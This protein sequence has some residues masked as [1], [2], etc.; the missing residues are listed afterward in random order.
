MLDKLRKRLARVLSSESLPID[1]AA[2]SIVDGRF[3]ISRLLGEGGTSSV[4]AVRQLS[5]D[6]EIALK[7]LRPDFETTGNAWDHFIQETRAVSRLTSPHTI[8]VYDAGQTPEG[9]FYIAME[10]LK[11][12]SLYQLTL[13]EP[14]PMPLGSAAPLMGQVLD[15]VEES[16]GAGVLHRDLKPDNIFLLAGA[17]NG[18]FAKVL[19]FG[20]ARLDGSPD[21]RDTRRGLVF[22]TPLYMSPEQ[23]EGRD[24]DARSDLYS[25]ALIL[26]EL[27]AGRP[28]FRE[29]DPL[30]L[31]L[32][33]LNRPA[34]SLAEVN[35]AVRV[36]KEIHAFLERGLARN[37]EDRPRDTVEFRNLLLIASD[38][39]E[40]SPLHL[41]ERRATQRIRRTVSTRFN[42]HGREFRATTTE[43]NVRGAYLY[44]KA[45]PRV[46]QKLEFTFTAPDSPDT[47]IHLSGE[48]VRV[49]EKAV[50][51]GEIRGFGVRW[52]FSR[53]TSVNLQT[54]TA[55]P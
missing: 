35:P 14:G 10:L 26:F 11:G 30:Q 5:M 31:A 25:L 1:L 15:S 53:Q 47:T 22:G 23:M 4:F 21:S 12:R 50:G 8:S 48:V 6:R 3:E 32:R 42:M 41:H 40:E 29:K 51:P 45:L 39:Y 9:L 46:G 55:H 7:I 2:G 36:P 19:D 34:P 49:V 43:M 28:P 16:H 27:L 20:V 13:D 33:K 52:N 18:C 17:G 24:I 38:G 54:A 37:P 44:S